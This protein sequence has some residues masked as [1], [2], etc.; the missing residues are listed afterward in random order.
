MADGGQLSIGLSGRVTIQNGG[1]L[2][3]NTGSVEVIGNLVIGNDATLTASSIGGL[4]IITINNI[5]T[6]PFQAVSN[7]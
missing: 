2:L 7:W 4:G 5:W 1:S 6:R 3:L